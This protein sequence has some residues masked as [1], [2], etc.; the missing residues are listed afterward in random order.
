MADSEKVT[1]SCHNGT[2]A[3]KMSWTEEEKE[4]LTSLWSGEDLLF[5]CQNTISERKQDTAMADTNLMSATFVTLLALFQ[6][7]LHDNCACVDGRKSCH[8]QSHLR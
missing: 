8:K 3:S 6:A 5:N 7:V 1:V 4:H 2:S